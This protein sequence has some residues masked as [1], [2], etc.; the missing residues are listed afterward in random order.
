MG[1]Q[2]M[3]EVREK[4]VDA[5]I[6]VILLLFGV[7][8]SILYYGHQVVPNSDFTSFFETGRQLLS[9]QLPDTYKRAPVL[10]IFQA[11]LSNIVGGAHPDLT[12]GWVLNACLLPLNL[13]L[14][15]LVGRKIVGWAAHWIALIAIIN[16]WVL[17]M[18]MQ[19][20]VETLFL[21]CILLSFYAIFH[22]SRWAY[23]AA[24]VTTM[25]RYDGALLILIVFV[26]DMLERKKG[27]SWFK[28]F[29]YAA[30]SSV[31]LGLW[32]LGTLLNWQTESSTHSL[33]EMGATSG[34]KILW[35]EYIYLIWNL[36]VKH[37]F[38]TEFFAP[39]ALSHIA[40]KL[41]KGLTL[42]SF[43]FGMGYGLVKRN[44][45]VLALAAFLGGYLFIHSAHAILR[46][47][48]GVPAFWIVLLI[49]VYG[50]TNGWAWI[51]RGNA[52]PEKVIWVLQG[53]A[54]ILITVWLLLLVLHVSEIDHISRRSISVPYVF[55]SVAALIF[56][57]QKTLLGGHTPWLKNLTITLLIILIGFSNQ[58]WLA[59]T[60]KDGK[61][62]LEF[63]LVAEWYIENA[64]PGETMLS[65]MSNVVRIFAPASKDAFI[66]INSISAEN[67]DAFI[68]ACYLKGLDYVVWDSKFGYTPDS[69]YGILWNLK[70]IKEL[71][72]PRDSG[73]F[74]FVEQ[75][76]VSENRFVNIFRMKERS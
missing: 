61:K 72:K 7:Y 29:L 69:R 39:K 73:P 75:I 62:N 33:K 64:K 30:L 59:D 32:M 19:P 26:V 63:K 53:A 17:Q 34:G 66:H 60:L 20:I 8:L 58:F 57:A 43:I 55:G 44:W 37:L 54:L 22:R 45:N 3:F 16:P 21:F 51:N 41:S 76:R 28:P 65:T 50:I 71:E 23:L 27:E 10:G 35:I 18:A 24:S 42:L 56:I 2:D 15:W 14:L 40:Y 12:A 13:I 47:R 9:L 68:E 38:E 25:V 31:P 36:G 5:F 48:Y 11:V 70:N 52:I 46:L 4:T 49:C 6:L 67:R 1:K 74:L